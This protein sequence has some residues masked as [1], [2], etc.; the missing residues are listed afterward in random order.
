MNNRQPL[1]RYTNEILA[2]E[3]DQRQPTPFPGELE[4]YLKYAKEEGGPILELSCGSG[5]LT[6]PMALAGF[7]V[8]GVDSSLAMLRRLTER[9]N[10]LDDTVRDK[11]RAYC[12]D[13]LTFSPN[14]HYAVILVPYNSIQELETHERIEVLFHR[15]VNLL[16]DPQDHY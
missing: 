8:D 2:W 11:I 4:W 9:F 10:G 5:R 1:V 16:I 6:V 3:Y 13:M 12:A 15:L 14:R 7:E